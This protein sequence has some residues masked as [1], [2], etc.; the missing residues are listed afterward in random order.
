MSLITAPVKVWFLGPDRRLRSKGH[1][2]HSYT[3]AELLSEPQGR[4]H[5]FSLLRYWVSLT[6]GQLFGP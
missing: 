6:A 3:A 5:I 4:L 1:V 2:L